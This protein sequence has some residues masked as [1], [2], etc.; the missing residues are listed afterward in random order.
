MTLREKI[1]SKIGLNGKG[2]LQV[3][4]P[5]GNPHRTVLN[6]YHNASL[7]SLHNYHLDTFSPIRPATG[8]AVGVF[9]FSRQVNNEG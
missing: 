8:R 2:N 5:P 6:A 4:F 9:T 1:S 7:Y 3:F